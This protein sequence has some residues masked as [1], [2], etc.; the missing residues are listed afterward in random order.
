MFDE[1]KTCKYLHS[2]YSNQFLL[3]INSSVRASCNSV[4]PAL[5]HIAGVKYLFH[6]AAHRK[7]EPA[8]AAMGD[9]LLMSFLVLFSES[10]EEARMEKKKFDGIIDY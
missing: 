8:F 6:L 5:R 3:D 10:L 1:L 4:S 7:Q 9:A 2:T